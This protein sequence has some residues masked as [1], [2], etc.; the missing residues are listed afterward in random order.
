MHWGYR[1]RA[2]T[3]PAQTPSAAGQPCIGPACGDGG[4]VR[5]IEDVEAWRVVAEVV[6]VERQVIDGRGG[7]ESRCGVVDMELVNHTGV[8]EATCVDGVEP[9][10]DVK[11]A[12]IDR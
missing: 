12:V 3:F 10:S 7:V 1:A 5:L 4:W 2:G 11:R 9:G 8:V 6:V